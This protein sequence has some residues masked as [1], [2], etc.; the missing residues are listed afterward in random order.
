M[1]SIQLSDKNSVLIP[2]CFWINTG[3][4][5]SSCTTVPDFP[6]AEV[7]PCLAV[8]DLLFLKDCKVDPL[9]LPPQPTQINSETTTL[10]SEKM[11]FIFF[12]RRCCRFENSVSTTRP[13]SGTFIQF[14]FFNLI[15]LFS[16]YC[17]N[18]PLVCCFL[19]PFQCFLKIFGHPCAMIVIETKL[20]F[21]LG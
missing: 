5:G 14:S 3:T 8:G 12:E 1:G 2:V 21:P 19:I 7:L 4:Q 10:I 17:R 9:S 16:P 18:I 11:F 6:D 20:I 15:K 13:A